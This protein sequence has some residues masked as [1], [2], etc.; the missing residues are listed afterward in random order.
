MSHFSRARTPGGVT[1]T[2]FYGFC[3]LRLLRIYSVSCLWVSQWAGCASYLPINQ[4]PDL[5]SSSESN[6]L[7]PV[8]MAAHKIH[9]CILW[10]S[11]CLI[12]NCV[13]LCSD[14]ANLCLLGSFVG[15]RLFLCFWLKT[16][17]LFLHPL[18]THLGRWLQ[19]SC[20]PC[21]IEYNIRSC[22]V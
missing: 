3:W 14:V 22:E 6:Y 21:L 8:R 15:W 7:N 10:W 17:H 4:M 18:Y 9:L 16:L 20:R 1:S 13:R 11:C 2:S 5:L 12:V 19:H